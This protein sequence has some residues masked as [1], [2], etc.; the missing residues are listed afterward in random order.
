MK[1]TL[2]IIFCCLP[3]FSFA[4]S[5]TNDTIV[6]A[7]TSFK[8]RHCRGTHGLCNM[9]ANVKEADLNTTITYDTINNTIL[10]FI[11]R[12]MLNEEE[13]F[14]VLRENQHDSAPSTE[15]FYLMDDDFIIPNTIAQLLQ[16]GREDVTIHKGLYPLTIFDDTITIS[17]KLQ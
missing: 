2:L 14:L 17:F 15:L 12:P 8:G 1:Y 11:N 7:K 4:Q 13:E 10:L 5:S 3:Y 16:I 6:T 9:D